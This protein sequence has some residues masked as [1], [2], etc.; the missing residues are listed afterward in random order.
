MTD[1]QITSLRLHNQQLVNPLLT[2]AGDVVSLL[3]AVQAQDYLGALW[4]VGQRMKKATE[5]DV[6]KAIT[7]K[8]IVRTWPMRGTLHFVSARDVRWMLKYLTPRVFQRMKS[9]LR[10]SEIDSK[11]ILKSKKLWAKA[12]QGGNQ[13]TRDEMYDVLEKGKISTGNVRGLHLTGVAAQDGLICFGP[14]KGKQQTFVLL[15]EWLPTY[16]M[17]TK[18]EAL[19]ELALRYFQSHGPATIEDFMWWAGLT[20]SDAIKGLEDAKSSL[21]SDD[22]DGKTYWFHPFK[23]VPKINSRKAWFLPTYDEYG[24]AYKDRSAIIH[25]ADY[26]KVGGTFTSGIVINGQVAGIWKRT[27]KNNIVIVEAKPF[28]SFNSRQKSAILGAEKRYSKFVEMPSKLLFV[29]SL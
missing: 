24:I 20:K 17:L 16:P 29:R 25:P 7:V 23:S 5:R 4:S 28:G 15:D 12:L 9:V 6:E 14:R 13:L 2:N 10:Q 26:K 19:A 3:G 27:I 11:V 18:A 1:N 22:A 8:A 21:A